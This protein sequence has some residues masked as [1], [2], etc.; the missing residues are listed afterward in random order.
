[1]D[2]RLSSLAWSALRDVVAV[3]G[4]AARLLWRH[5]PVL[6]SLFLAGIVTHEL[7]MR[8]AVEASAV[9][10]VLGFLVFL[11]GPIA[12]LVAFILMLRALRPSLPWLSRTVREAPQDAGRASLLNQVGSVLTPFAAVYVSYG[13]LAK[14]IGDYAYRVWEDEALAN[15]EAVTTP[16]TM[17]VLAR[18]P[19]SLG[20]ATASVALVAFVLRWVVDRWAAVERRP[21]LGLPAAYAEIIWITLGAVAVT[22][23]STVA[24]DWLQAR[25]LVHWLSDLWQSVTGALGPLTGPTRGAGS[26]LWGLVMNSLNDVVVIPIAWLIVGAVVYGHQI[27]P[28]PPAPEDLARRSRQRWSFLPSAL[29]TV[30]GQVAALVIGRF[31]ALVHGVRLIFRA[32]LGPMLLFCLAFVVAASVQNWLWELERLLIGPRDLATFWMPW[33]GPL[34]TLNNVIAWTL[35]ACLLG[36]AIDRVLRVERPAT[37]PGA[38]ATAPGSAA[39]SAEAP[40]AP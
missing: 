27:A 34:G 18:L 20:V 15:A 1:M 28:Q 38:A 5:W 17:D 16:G 7:L 4:T 31:S 11:L 19:T 30:N 33:S 29:H 13:Y 8:L 22:Q 23:V 35:L 9:H 6:V 21:W 36:A 2:R 12:M 39:R 32:G 37:A 40:S 26:W 14:D 25:R 3:V 10:A 24:T